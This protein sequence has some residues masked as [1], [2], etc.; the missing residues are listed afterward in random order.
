MR[1][2]QQQGAAEYAY[3]ARKYWQAVALHM[4]AASC[5]SCRTRHVACI[6]AAMARDVHVAHR[7]QHVVAMYV[8]AALC[9]SCSL[10]LAACS[11]ACPCT[12]GRQCATEC[13]PSAVSLQPGHK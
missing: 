2:L 7:Y 13:R 6:A 8:L 3:E 5:L 1:Q 9:L 11:L 10:Q 12:A 4:S